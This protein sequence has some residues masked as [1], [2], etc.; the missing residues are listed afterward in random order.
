MKL[1][2]NKLFIFTLVLVL[3]AVVIMLVAFLGGGQNTPLGRAMG[4]VL[5]PLEDGLSR[6]GGWFSNLFGYFHRYNALEAERDALMAEVIR[7]RALETEYWEAVNENE[8]LRKLNNLRAKHRDFDLEPCSVISYDGTGYQSAF[9][10]NRGEI[11]GIEVGDPVVVE[12]GLVG[13]V[14]QVGP[15]YAN[16][17]TLLHQKSTAGAMVS[18]TREVAVAGGDFQLSEKGQLKLSY[19]SNDAKVAVGDW[20]ESTGTGGNFPKGLLVGKVLAVELEQHGGSSYAVLEP[21]VDLQNL[22][23]VF[24]VKSFNITD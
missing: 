1:L 4:A 2:R 6:V 8:E 15:N 21:V 19:L 18:R 11:S 16:V 17:V 7:L 13:F 14:T 10:I 5:T 20:V 12:A 9:T 22:T 23:G 3:V 24:V